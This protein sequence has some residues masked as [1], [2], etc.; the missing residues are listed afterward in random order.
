MTCRYRCRAAPSRGGAKPDFPRC[1]VR[2]LARRIRD[3]DFIFAARNIID[4]RNLVP[5][6]SILVQST[7]QLRHRTIDFVFTVMSPGK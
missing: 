5:E 7:K 6:R 1:S 3:F 4:L 2:R